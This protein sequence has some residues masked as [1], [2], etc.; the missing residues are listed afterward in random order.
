[1]NAIARFTGKACGS[2]AI[3]VG[4]GLGVKVGSSVR[5]ATALD[6]QDDVPVLGI[7]DF[8][9]VGLVCDRKLARAST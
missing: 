3:R 5:R 8:D 9:R 4:I 6:T 1:M 7:L 2:L